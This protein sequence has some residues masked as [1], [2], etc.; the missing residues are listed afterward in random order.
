MD[1]PISNRLQIT[2]LIHFIVSAI[3]GAAMWLIPGRTL[4]LLGWVGEFIQLPGAE[5]SIRGQT[6]VDPFISRLFGAALLALAFSSFLGW[7][8]KHWEQVA[9]VVQQEAVFCVLGVAA[10][11]AVLFL[12]ERPMPL[13]GWGVLL[14]LAGFAVAWGVAWQTDGRAAKA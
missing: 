5:V 11:F 9:L 13:S 7:R 10:F 2:F 3:L 6:F 8:A 14:L 4:T 12:A 1:R